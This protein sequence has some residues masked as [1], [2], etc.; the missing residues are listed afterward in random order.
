ME[1]GL[2][3]ASTA[4]R[5]TTAASGSSVTATTEETTTKVSKD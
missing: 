1:T 5:V 3:S 4:G 2:A